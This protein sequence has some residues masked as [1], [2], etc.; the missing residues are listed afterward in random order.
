MTP[1]RQ[2]MCEEMQI[3]NLSPATQRTYL[4]AVT[5]FAQHFGQS[6]AELGPAEV[7][8]YQLHLLAQQRSI[9]TLTI[10]VC[11]LRFLYHVTL[12]QDWP[13]RRSLIPGSPSRSRSS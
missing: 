13:S 2:R 12:H 9:S 5:Q 11:A 1:L 4:T 7:W 3:R 6:P 8:T 10:T